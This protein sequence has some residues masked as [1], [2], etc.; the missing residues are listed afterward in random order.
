MI[1][2]YIKQNRNNMLVVIF[3]AA[4][5]LVITM[6]MT[7]VWFLSLGLGIIA[8]NIT[9]NQLIAAQA[10][11]NKKLKDDF[12]KLASS[13]VYSPNLKYSVEE[14]YSFFKDIGIDLNKI[15]AV[16][17]SDEDEPN[18]EYPMIKINYNNSSHR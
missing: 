3:L 12:L 10:P 16:E 8:I 11:V 4:I 13:G 6:L 5:T 2:R 7:Q 18:L 17:V 1:D 9:A 14:Y 15:S